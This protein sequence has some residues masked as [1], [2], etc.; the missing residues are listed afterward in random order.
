LFAQTSGG[1]GVLRSL[2]LS[3]KPKG[4]SAL[5]FS[6]PQ[7][8][9]SQLFTEESLLTLSFGIRNANDTAQVYAWSVS[10]VR[11]GHST[12]VANGSDRVAAGGEVTVVRKILTD[13]A[14]GQLEFVV[15][16]AHTG[17]SISYWT[18][19]VSAS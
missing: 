7:S 18:T 14:G 9:I 16:L 4:Y 1:H 5:Y 8:L 19:C 12:D 17:E 10:T 11:S 15:Q 13:C 2:G 6:S 3:A